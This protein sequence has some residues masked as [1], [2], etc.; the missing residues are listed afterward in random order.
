MLAVLHPNSKSLCQTRPIAHQKSPNTFEERKERIRYN[1][2]S[3]WDKKQ[4][5]EGVLKFQGGDDEEKS[6]RDPCMGVACLEALGGREGGSVFLWC[7][8]F[9]NILN[10]GVA[11]F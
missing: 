8:C 10:V 4:L 2:H 3:R 1:I 11:V 6:F 7:V 5:H 9:P